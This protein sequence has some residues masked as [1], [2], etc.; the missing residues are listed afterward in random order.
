MSGLHV[1]LLVAAGCAAGMLNVVA[2]AGAPV[3]FL[4]LLAIGLPV[5]VA[6]ASNLAGMP[7]SFLLAIVRI[8]RQ[9]AAFQ[10]YWQVAVVAA[11]GC[12]IG[13][14]VVARTGGAW[15]WMAA[16]VFLLFA[17]VLIWAQP[18][19]QP[20]PAPVGPG[21]ARRPELR[22]LA[23]G[24][25]AVWEHGAKA[26]QVAD[27]EQPAGETASRVKLTRRRSLVLLGAALFATGVYAGVFGG[28]VGGLVVVVLLFVGHF[29]DRESQDGKLA[30]CFVTSVVGAIAFGFLGPVDWHACLA[31]AVGMVIGGFFGGKLLD[32]MPTKWLRRGVI[33]TTVGAA[34][35]LLVWRLAF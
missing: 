2:V 12:V 9:R 15:L 8:W 10:P 28:G 29:T 4:A 5:P 32:R 20:Q 16:P 1:L 35:W 24:T 31:V 26:G 3:T 21:G 25:S 13:V 6:N 11:V 27:G 30:I 7:A 18:K 34:V 17:A 22:V 23:D 33:A 19:L 14:V